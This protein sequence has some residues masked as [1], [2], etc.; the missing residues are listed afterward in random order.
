MIKTS[1]KRNAGHPWDE[2]PGFD[3]LFI[4]ADTPL[5]L[6]KAVASAEAKFWTPWLVGTNGYTGLPVGVFFKPCGI[7]QPWEDAPNNR[8]PGI[9]V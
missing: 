4:D 9:I 8:H 3:M 5:E 2:R 6:D 7:K 1:V